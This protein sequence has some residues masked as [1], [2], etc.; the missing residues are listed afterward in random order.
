MSNVNGPQKRSI[1]TRTEPMAF[2]QL[3][4]LHSLC[5]L[6]GGDVKALEKKIDELQ[7]AVESIGASGDTHHPLAIPKPTPTVA[8]HPPG[9]SCSCRQAADGGEDTQLKNFRR[10]S[11]SPSADETPRKEPKSGEDL[12]RVGVAFQELLRCVS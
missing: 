3:L 1:G 11:A 4:K 2:G 9:V 6:Q 7:A 5:L 12:H 8:V 10:P